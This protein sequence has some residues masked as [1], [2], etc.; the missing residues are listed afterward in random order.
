LE[1]ELTESIFLAPVDVT[2]KTLRE[3]KDR[4]VHLAIDDFGTGYSSLNYL[5]YFPIDR[6]KIDQSFIRDIVTEK[7]DAAIVEAIIA[8]ARSPGID[9]IA[10]DVE[11]RE[12][13]EFLRGRHCHE[14]QGYYFARPMPINELGHYFHLIKNGFSAKL[15]KT[16]MAV[17]P[18]SILESSSLFIPVLSATGQ[19]PPAIRHL[20]LWFRYEPVLPSV[21]SL[22]EPA[23]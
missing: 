22:L 20:P 8:M 6:L 19:Q 10:E 17:I 3:L 16:P 15:A 21:M 12:Q 23:I 14:M 13:L 18:P 1:L 2:L 5:K 9:I 4:G 7:D 11:T